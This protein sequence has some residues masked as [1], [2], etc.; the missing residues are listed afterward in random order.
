MKCGGEI[1]HI[2]LLFFCPRGS[3]ALHGNKTCCYCEIT[4]LGPSP[5][6]RAAWRS[7]KESF[8]W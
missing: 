1:R 2:S 6:G 4:R 5:Q 8:R 3:R 7:T